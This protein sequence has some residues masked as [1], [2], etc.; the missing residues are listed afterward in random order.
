MKIKNGNSIGVS[1]NNYFT[2]NNISILKTNKK[3]KSKENSNCDSFVKSIFNQKA[4]MEDMTN[5]ISMDN[6][7][8]QLKLGEEKDKCIEGI[9][10]ICSK[11]EKLL[12]G[13]KG[14]SS[15]LDFIL[16]GNSEMVTQTMDFNEVCKNIGN[17]EYSVVNNKSEYLK[18][19]YN[20]GA[21]K[22]ETFYKY[23]GDDTGINVDEVMSSNKVSDD[24]KT[25][26]GILESLKDAYGKLY[27]SMDRI[28][29]FKEESAKRLKELQENMQKN[30]QNITEQY[31]AQ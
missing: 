12:S 8:R 5:K 9:K 25:H 29:N 10:K 24:V 13:D 11:N 19:Y 16:S 28:K 18:K 14:Y 6:L 27:N 1:K 15:K 30:M 2:K 23:M 31:K 3:D 7:K 17:L 21:D 22:K 4:Q 26:V 20:E